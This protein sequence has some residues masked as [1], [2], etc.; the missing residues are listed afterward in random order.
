MP[1]TLISVPAVGDLW[2]EVC[3]EQIWV[4]LDFSV[5]TTET[6]LV[7]I[8]GKESCWLTFNKTIKGDSKHARDKDQEDDNAEEIGATSIEVYDFKNIFLSFSIFQVIIEVSLI[9]MLILVMF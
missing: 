8:W 4:L 2:L 3:N 5:D 7:I 1:L 6:I 9:L